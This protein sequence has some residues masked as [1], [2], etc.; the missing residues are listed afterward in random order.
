MLVEAVSVMPEATRRT[1]A[2]YLSSTTRKAKSV[3]VHMD[4]VG[5]ARGSASSQAQ[6][7]FEGEAAGLEAILRTNTLR[8]PKPVKVL[9]H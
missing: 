7:M 9:T 5:V 6:V 2:P 3:V 4:I 1:R 8:V